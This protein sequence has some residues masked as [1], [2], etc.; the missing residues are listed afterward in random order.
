[1]YSNKTPTKKNIMGVSWYYHYP[2]DFLRPYGQATEGLTDDT[3]RRKLTNINTEFLNR[4]RMA[5]SLLADTFL[6]NEET[7]EEACTMGK[8]IEKFLR[9][10][11]PLEEDFKVLSNRDATS[12]DDHAAVRNVMTS[13]AQQSNFMVEFTKKCGHIGGSLYTTAMWLRSTNYLLNN[14]DITKEKLHPDANL[15]NFRANVTLD[16]LINDVCTGVENLSLVKKVDSVNLDQLSSSDEERPPLV[17]KAKRKLDLS[18]D[19]IEQPTT[20]KKKKKKKDKK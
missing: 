18:K 12:G 10:M 11:E 19:D 6:S 14:L 1:M 9:K 8:H 2:K 13:I 16:S 15:P 4:P 7:M 3:M 20:S 5:L 17:N